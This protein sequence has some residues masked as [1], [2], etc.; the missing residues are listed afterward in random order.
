MLDSCQGDVA[1]DNLT[2]TS[3]RRKDV[4]FT[5]PLFNTR[6]VLVQRKPDNWP[7]LSPLQLETLLVKNPLQ[8]SER[9]VY[10]RKGSSFYERLK[11]LSNEIGGKI[12]V[13]ETPGNETTEEL[14][15]DVAKG[16]IDFT[17]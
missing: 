1:A 7:K 16:K 17:I 11:D 4:E 2:V 8:L 10:V 12:N 6:Q 15:G 14:M 5:S 3:N 9:Q 13:I